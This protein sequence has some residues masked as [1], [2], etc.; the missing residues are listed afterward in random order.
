LFLQVDALV[1]GSL[2]WS[3]AVPNLVIVASAV[4]AP[5]AEGPIPRRV[6]ASVL[7]LLGRCLLLA[8]HAM[9]LGW[10]VASPWLLQG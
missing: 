2:G 10:T 7:M 1:A 5:G 9:S 6:P 4:R 8:L 3:T